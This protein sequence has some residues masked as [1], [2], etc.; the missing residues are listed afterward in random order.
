MKFKTYFFGLP[1]SE[2]KLFA[3]NV[4][5]SVGHLTNFSYGYT[6]L[7][8]VTCAAIEKKTSNAI[9]RK[10]LRPDDFWKIWPDLEHLAPNVK[11]QKKAA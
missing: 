3:E 1:K 5:T 11:K 6:R 10:D 7:A 4:G 2:R 8:P 9:T